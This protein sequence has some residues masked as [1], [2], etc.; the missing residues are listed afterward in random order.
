MKFSEAW[1]REWAN[2]AI[3]TDTLAAKLTMAGLEVDAVTPAAPAFSG[4]VVAEIISAEQH[5][6]ADKHRR[7]ELVFAC[8]WLPLVL[9]SPVTLKSREP[10]YAVLNHWVCFVGVTS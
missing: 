2:P 8:P 1:L 3:D 10:S 5:P 7:R 4:V 6:N 9:C